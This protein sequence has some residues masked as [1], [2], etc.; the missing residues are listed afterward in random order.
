MQ[1]AQQLRMCQ[2]ASLLLDQP[3]RQEGC[4]FA[5]RLKPMLVDRASL[6]NGIDYL[7]VEF[8]ATGWDRSGER[9]D[10]GS[11]TQHERVVPPGRDARMRFKA[12]EEGA[13]VA[14]GG[15]LVVGHLP[16]Y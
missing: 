14:S 12:F 15:N 3:E 8:R 6:E 4:G 10:H 7:A 1:D 2:C 16:R 5:H 11:Q 13:S 9:I